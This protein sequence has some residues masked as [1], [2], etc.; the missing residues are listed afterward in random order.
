MAVSRLC[1]M[2]VWQCRDCVVCRYGSV[3]TVWY[4]G[5]AVSRLCG[6]SV[7]QCRDSDDGPNHVNGPTGGGFHQGE[8]RAVPQ[9]HGSIYR[10]RGDK[11][12]SFC[13]L[14]K[15]LRDKRGLKGSLGRRMFVSLQTIPSKD[16]LLTST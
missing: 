6:M 14:L 3:A 15:G 11:R 7:W 16:N 5:M 4:V 9:K 2:S 8:P 13:L 12:G 10:K 1:G